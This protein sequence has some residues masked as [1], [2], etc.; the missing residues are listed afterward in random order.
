M[1]KLSDVKITNRL[2]LQIK[3]CHFDK[4]QCWFNK[5]VSGDPSQ[6]THLDDLFQ[7]EISKN[8]KL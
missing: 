5:K 1:E 7:K 4:D 3:T 2:T 6:I 8:L